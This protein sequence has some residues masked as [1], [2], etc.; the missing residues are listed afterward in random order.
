MVTFLKFDAIDE[1]RVPILNKISLASFF[2]FFSVREVQQCIGLYTPKKKAVEQLN[3]LHSF[4][5]WTPMNGCPTSNTACLLPAITEK[6]TKKKNK[7]IINKNKKILNCFWWVATLECLT[8]MPH[9]WQVDMVK[10]VVKL[11]KLIWLN[12]WLNWSN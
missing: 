9:N 7:K 8:K 1:L 11:V 6:K 10:P 12:Q 4:G 3:C 2:F 5:V